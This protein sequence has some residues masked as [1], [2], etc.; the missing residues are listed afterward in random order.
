MIDKTN[1]A[2]G[3]FFATFSS[4]KSKTS[5]SPSSRYSMVVYSLEGFMKNVAINE[6]NKLLFPENG[7]WRS[8]LQIDPLTGKVCTQTID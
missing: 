2:I 5:P 1:I 3:T 6:L 4:N 7:I 8:F